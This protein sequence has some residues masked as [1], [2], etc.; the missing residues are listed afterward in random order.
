VIQ[1]ALVRVSHVRGAQKIGGVVGRVTAVPDVPNGGSGW[2]RR[3]A[4]FPQPAKQ[5]A[6]LIWAWPDVERWARKTGRLPRR[7]RSGEARERLV[8]V[9]LFKRHVEE[10]APLPLEGRLAAWQ[11]GDDRLSQLVETARL[12]RTSFTPAEVERV[13]IALKSGERIYAIVDRAGL[14]EPRSTGGR[15]VGGYQGVSVRVPGTKSMRYRIGATKGRCVRAEEKPTAIDTGTA[16][17]T[18]RRVVFVGPKQTREWLWGKV[19]AVEHE[20]DA[21][22]TAVPVENRQ[23]VSGIAYSAPAAPKVRFRLDLAQAVAAGATDALVAELEA[24]R[25]E[26]AQHRPG[27][28]LPPPTTAV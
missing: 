15:W 5:E 6:A 21:P 12:F 28:P 13:P 23:K 19:I 17:V 24:D 25:A 26:H 8:G 7:L 1:R 11:T 14:I 18:D 3:H 4:D 10:R 27:A 20:P 9:G 16:V 2:R 22:W